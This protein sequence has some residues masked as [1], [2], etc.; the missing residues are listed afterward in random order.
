MLWSFFQRI[1]LVD[2]HK[3]EE[4][5]RMAIRSACKAMAGSLC[6]LLVGLPRAAT[7]ASRGGCIF[8]EGRLE[9]VGTPGIRPANI[10][11]LGETGVGTGF[12]SGWSPFP[13]GVQ[14]FIWEMVLSIVSRIEKRGG[15]HGP[16]SLPSGARSILQ[17]APWWNSPL[18]ESTTWSLAAGVA[19]G[20]PPNLCWSWW[21]MEELLLGMDHG[22]PRP[23]GAALI[24]RKKKGGYVQPVVMFNQLS[25]IGA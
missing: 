6:P 25:N 20:L 24:F 4:Q 5:K 8:F 23:L 16:H 7:S 17:S 3:K 11:K 10:W 15:W 18:W 9:H 22:F 13:G 12:S 21:L 1:S 14:P 2:K 19:V